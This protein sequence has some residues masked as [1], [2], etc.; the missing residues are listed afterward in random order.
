MEGKIRLMK[1]YAH[2]QAKDLS[3]SRKASQRNE[4]GM[5]M[6]KFFD[7]YQVPYK[8]ASRALVRTGLR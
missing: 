1:L 3:R 7:L 6:C 8:E 4:K 2:M 5:E